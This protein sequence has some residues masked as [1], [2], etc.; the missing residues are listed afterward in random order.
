MIIDLYISTCPAH[1]GDR[2]RHEKKK[3][4]TELE[5]STCPASHTARQGHRIS[6]FV[7]FAPCPSPVLVDGV[8]T[9]D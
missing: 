4:I 8:I 1:D 9:D 2:S 7:F 6:G 5:F 3:C